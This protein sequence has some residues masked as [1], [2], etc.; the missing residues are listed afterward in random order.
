M[1]NITV[2]SATKILESCL[3]GKVM[4]GCVFYQ[5]KNKLRWQIEVLI[6]NVVR[7]FTHAKLKDRL[8]N[9]NPK[10]SLK[11]ASIE[12]LHKREIL[13]E[14]LKWENTRGIFFNQLVI[15]WEGVFTISFVQ[16]LKT[17]YHNS[18]LTQM[19]IIWNDYNHNIGKKKNIKIQIR[20]ML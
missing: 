18:F 1:P 4:Y 10:Y 2:E 14:M 3:I 6:M 11:L 19:Q 20:D 12:T 8:R 15:E 17:K 16:F 7:I 13:H 9:D 5:S